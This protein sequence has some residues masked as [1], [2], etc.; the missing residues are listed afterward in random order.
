MW[1]NHGHPRRMRSEP[2][3]NAHTEESI[4]KR[5]QSIRNLVEE[6]VSGTRELKT[7][8]YGGEDAAAPQ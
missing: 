3:S 7:K 8:M 2:L 5:D 6:L 1:K 4:D